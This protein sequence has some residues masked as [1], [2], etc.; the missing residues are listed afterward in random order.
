[1]KVQ[2]DFDK[3]PD[4]IAIVGSRSFEKNKI[5]RRRFRRH[6]EEFVSRL[7]SYTEVVS[8]GAQGIDTYAY[9]A[10][11]KYNNPYTIFDP[12][13]SISSPQ[14]YFDRN[15]SIVEYVKEHNGLVVAF[16]DLSACRGTEDTLRKARRQ[17]VPTLVFTFTPDGVFQELEGDVDLYR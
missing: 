13:K 9:D 15:S 10:A 4:T 8:G 7:K 6:V 2:I 3:L 11:V 1:M 16:V 5:L 14:R 17:G 12:D